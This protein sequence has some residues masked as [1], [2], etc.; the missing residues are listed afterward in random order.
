VLAIGCPQAFALRLG[1]RIIFALGNEP[2]SVRPPI[3]SAIAQVSSGLFSQCCGLKLC[4]KGAQPVGDCALVS[5]PW[6]GQR[7]RGQS[8][9]RTETQLTNTQ[10]VPPF[11]LCSG[12]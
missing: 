12:A 5:R 9:G 7:W 4:E 6:G 3:P 8:N 1:K 10:L 11:I 2:D